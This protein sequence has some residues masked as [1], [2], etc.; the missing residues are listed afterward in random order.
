[1]STRSPQESLRLLCAAW[2]VLSSLALARE[3]WHETYAA[4]QSAAKQSGKQIFLC[5][6]GK[7]WSA[8]CRQFEEHF[9]DQPEFTQRLQRHFEAVQ[10]DV[11]AY[12]YVTAI[13]E[14]N[15][16]EAARLKRE[17]EVTTFPVVFL[18]DSEERPYAVTGFRPG[19]IE[20]YGK[21]LD[22]LRETQAQQK[23]L[24]ARARQSSGVRRAE[25]LAQAI[26]EIGD[27]RTVRF[28]G[29][30]MREVVA[31]DPEDTT[32]FARKFELKLGDHD[33][34]QKMREL[35]QD[36]R[37]SEMLKL[38]DDYIETYKLS[39]SELQA[40]LMNRFDIL[41]RQE[42]LPEMILTLDRV[43]RLNPYNPH[44]RQARQLLSEMARQIEEQALLESLQ[45]QE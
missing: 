30:L 13:D 41:R 42:N 40:A 2:L 45:N 5:F 28:Y 27:L 16:S 18:I 20:S 12:R 8:V 34:V 1:M 3:G 25:L 44:G 43:Y 6:T 32:G 26:P 4:A 33:Y 19:G 11:S 9:L 39:G 29:D 24:L 14:K 15:S 36:L 21:H 22:K 38:T 31:L 10:L 23:A 35:D 37:W 17:F 7:D